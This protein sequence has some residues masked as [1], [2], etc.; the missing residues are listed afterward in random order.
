MSSKKRRFRKDIYWK[1]SRSHNFVNAVGFFYKWRQNYIVTLIHRYWIINLLIK[2]QRII[3]VQLQKQ[4]QRLYPN[5]K[6]IRIFDYKDEIFDSTFQTFL[7]RNTYTVHN[8]FKCCKACTTNLFFK[9][10]NN[11]LINVAQDFWKFVGAR[12]WHSVAEKLWTEFELKVEPGKSIN[13]CIR[14]DLMT[15]SNQLSLKC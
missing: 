5:L 1:K 14:Y 3:D 6:I 9:C 4:L 8:T 15:L 11:R 7:R 12:R 10:R 2:I 13:C